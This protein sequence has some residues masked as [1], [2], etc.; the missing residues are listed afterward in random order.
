MY[1]LLATIICNNTHQNKTKQKK[2][3]LNINILNLHEEF[4]YFNKG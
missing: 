1:L 4:N 2:K 3:N